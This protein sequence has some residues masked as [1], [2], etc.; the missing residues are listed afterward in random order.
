MK[1]TSAHRLL[2]LSASIATLAPST[3]VQAD[4]NTT[5]LPQEKSNVLHMENHAQYGKQNLSRKEMF[6]K[7][8]LL[9]EEQS[10]AEALHVRNMLMLMAVLRSQQSGALSVA[11][12]SN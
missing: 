3:I 9:R 8:R 5:R 11:S 6:E 10:D 1:A 4:V 7:R 12:V 2:A